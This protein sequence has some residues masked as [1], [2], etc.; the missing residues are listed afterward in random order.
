MRFPEYLSPSS[1]ECAESTPT[2][3][4]LRYLADVKPPK[5]PQTNAMAAGSAF[6]AYVK[7]YLH[8]QLIGK[9]PKYELR[10]LFESQVESHNRNEAWIV[11][12]GLFSKY[13]DSGALAEL[14]LQ[15]SGSIE[16][17]RFE[18]EIHGIIGA[19][20]GT[21]VAVPILGKPDL[22]FITASGADVV[23]DWK[24]NGFYSNSPPSPTAGY[25]QLLSEGPSG[26]TRAGQHK[27]AMIHDVHG[28]QCN[29][30][31]YFNQHDSKW[32]TQLATYSWLLGAEV[33]AETLVGIHQLVCNRRDSRLR[34][35]IH[36]SRISQQFQFDVLARYQ[37]LWAKLKAQ[38]FHF[39]ETLTLE[40]SQAKCAGLESQAAGINAG[41]VEGAINQ[42][43]REER[44]W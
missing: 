40:E 41:G 17:P 19:S 25:I 13:K 14:M 24:V 2:E 20:I 3:Y 34:I 9:N 23:Y 29:I 7:S 32:A 11:G 30:G 42:W 15:L 28:I 26:W 44:G 8:E 16:T 1:L 21:A 12:A 43:G 36:C 10:T 22:R 35:A 33:G 18:F 4:Y 31:S 6:D 39:F 37:R 27:D 5:I 38:P